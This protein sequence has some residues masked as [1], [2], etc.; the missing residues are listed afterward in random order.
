MATGKSKRGLR[1]PR[2][3]EPGSASDPLVV[4][5]SAT[6]NYNSIGLFAGNEALV[7]DPGLSPPEISLLKARLA[8][9]GAPASPRAIRYLILTHAHHD[10]IRG[11]CSFEGARTFMPRIAAD[12]GP[13]ARGRILAAGEA[14]GKRMGSSPP[15]FDWPK[16]SDPF[17]KGASLLLGNSLEVRMH[18]LPGHSNC[19]S[20]VIIPSLHTLLS[21]DYLVSPGVPFCR[22]EARM[23]EGALVELGDLVDEYA[24]ERLV[25]SH[26]PMHLGKEAINAALT[27]DRRVMACMRTAVRNAVARNQTQAAIVT[28]A[29]AA[30][31]SERGGSAGPLAAQ[32]MD[33]A[34]RILREER[35]SDSSLR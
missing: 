23:F 8:T 24:I 17:D 14:L 3:L 22:H 29:L 1:F 7:V 19:T 2:L 18:F 11:G 15:G 33:N 4:L 16:V 12:K 9:A 27:R 21:A 20:V 5:R 32:D 34:R 13:D 35:L 26:G 31:E 10:H 25:P 30:A 28:A 6:W